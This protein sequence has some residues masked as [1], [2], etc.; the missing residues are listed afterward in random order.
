MSETPRKLAVFPAFHKVDGARVV[1]AGDG[2]AAGAKVRLLA[3]TSASI[4]VFGPTLDKETGADLVA[5]NG[6]WVPRLPEAGD[7]DGAALAFIATGD[8]ATDW[9]LTALA[10]EAGVPVNVVDRPEL[11]DFFT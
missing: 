2:E 10:R 11:C 8:E 3:E 4:Q 6:A 1:I 9:A 7:F 5:A